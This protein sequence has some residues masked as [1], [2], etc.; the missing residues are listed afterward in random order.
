MRE[1]HLD[2]K[3]IAADVKQVLGL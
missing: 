2:P 1:S 3:L